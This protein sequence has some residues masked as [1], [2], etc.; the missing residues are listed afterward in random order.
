MMR[1]LLFLATNLAVVL[2]AS[3]TLS[4]FG[5]NGFMAANG[6]DLNLNQLLVFCAVLW[7]CRLDLLA[8]HLQM[9][10][11]DEHQHPGHHPATHPP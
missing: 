1:I 5:F 6:V 9:D 2:I 8:V 10:G 11:E 7:F 3:I 4:L